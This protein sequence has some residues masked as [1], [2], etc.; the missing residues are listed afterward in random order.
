[1][2][3]QL[4]KALF[5]KTMKRAYMI[6]GVILL[7]M[8][9]VSA[10]M[11]APVVVGQNFLKNLKVQPE[12][13]VSGNNVGG[14]SFGIS[15]DVF[16]GFDKEDLTLDVPVLV[17]IPEHTQPQAEEPEAVDIFKG[18]YT[19]L[20]V[21]NSEFIEASSDFS[22]LKHNY[23]GLSIPS[24]LNKVCTLLQPASLMQKRADSLYEETLSFKSYV[25]KIKANPGTTELKSKAVLMDRITKLE[26]KF[27]S[28]TGDSTLLFNTI[29]SKCVPSAPADNGN[30]NDNGNDNQ[31]NDNGADD[32]SDDGSDN[33]SDDG[34]DSQGDNSLDLTQY[35]ALYAELSE[36]LTAMLAN[37]DETKVDVIS[38]YCSG[39]VAG[40][41]E[42]KGAALFGHSFMYAIL[43]GSAANAQQELIAMDET[44]LASQ[45]GQIVTD[46]E[47][48][49]VKLGEFAE[50]ELV[51]G[52]CSQTP[53][54]D[55]VVPGDTVNPGDSNP[56]T[57]SVN[58]TTQTTPQPTVKTDADKLNDFED[59][60]NKYNDDYK[61]LKENIDD[62]KLDND[63]EEVDDLMDELKDLYKDVKSLYTDVAEFKGEV[64]DSL[65]DEVSDLKDS[66]KSLKS[67]INC[68][69]DGQS[70]NCASASNSEDE[71]ED[72]IDEDYLPVFNT[73][74]TNEQK[75]VKKTAVKEQKKEEVQVI[76]TS[77]QPEQQIPANVG[78]SSAKT[79]QP[80][81]TE[82]STYLAMLISGFVLLLGIAVFLGAVA[83]R[84]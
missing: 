74:N 65:Y 67:K 69:L 43:K 27:R 62:A 29:R 63:E 9:T 21:L 8:I 1:M 23:L 80:S 36:T 24:R 34:S 79:V 82:S 14:N 17:P 56:A 61:E 71:S 84:M 66:I 68:V 44:E 52:L 78:T 35:E 2:I 7:T 16:A 41:D 77:V 45:F 33:G 54:G 76:T 4:L 70:Q 46:S 26:T 28:L 50:Q 39:D 42:M 75:T 13:E 59:L 55:D 37:L 31:G 38:T 72:V 11:A 18:F 12:F 40:A 73:P 22:E 6:L 53:P 48:Y 25:L 20:N 10:A 57:P 19:K 83:L 49:L 5:S 32:G 30:G 58:Q 60:Y 51:Q 47:A 64:Q 81:F 3:N 15:S